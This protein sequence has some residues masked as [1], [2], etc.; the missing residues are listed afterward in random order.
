MVGV[1]RV[2]KSNDVQIALNFFG[3]GA[4]QVAE[5]RDGFRNVSL[6]CFPTAQKI[7]LS[8]LRMRLRLYGM[9]WCGLRFGLLQYDIDTQC[10]AVKLDVLAHWVGDMEGT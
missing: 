1:E 8:R 9:L 6:F 5:N 4:L 3:R 2:S 7:V 10:S